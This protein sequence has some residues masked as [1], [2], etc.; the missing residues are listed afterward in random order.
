M[1]YKAGRFVWNSGK[2][3]SNI[4]KHGV[5][6]TTASSVFFDVKRKTFTD[7]KHSIIEPRYFCIGKV[8]NRIITVRFTYRGGMI[9]IYGAGYW[10]RGEYYY[11]K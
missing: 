8:N 10:R 2:E 5:D 9:R 4:S 3:R 1:E 11:E 6:F 7:S